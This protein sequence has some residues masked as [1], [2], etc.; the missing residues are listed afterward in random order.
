MDAP[1]FYLL[2]IEPKF[3]ALLPFSNIWHYWDSPLKMENIQKCSRVS[4]S[5][6]WL[7]FSVASFSLH[8]LNVG[9]LQTLGP[10][11][12]SSSKE[13]IYV[14]GLMIF[15]LI[16]L[17]YS[18]LCRAYCVLPIAC[19]R[20]PHGYLSHLMQNTRNRIHHTSPL[21][22]FTWVSTV[23]K[24]LVQARNPRTIFDSVPHL[25]QYKYPVL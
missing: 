12:L 7:R 9:V 15:R 11:L 23:T 13:L 2:V 4:H 8:P 10:E 5:S 20:P 17:V 16:T 25:P 24:T 21:L 18:S 1:A 3:S 22:C 6:L 14:P 19:E